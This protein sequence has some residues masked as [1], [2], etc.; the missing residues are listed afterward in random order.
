MTEALDSSSMSSLSRP[1]GMPDKETAEEWLNNVLDNNESM[2]IQRPEDSE[3]NG[4]MIARNQA[5]P[6][7]VNVFVGVDDQD[8]QQRQ[9]YSF[10]MSE[11]VKSLVKFDIENRFRNLTRGLANG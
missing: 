8:D 9:G 11:R 1:D 7:N 4:L 2:L 6:K 5:D 10:G 3:D